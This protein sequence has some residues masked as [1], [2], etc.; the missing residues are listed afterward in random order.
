MSEIVLENISKTFETKDGTVEALKNVSL[1]I[2]KGEIYGVIGMSGAGKSTLVRCINF[3]EKPDEGKVLI[4][5]K[6][7]DDFSKKELQKQR[8]SIGMIFQHFN[9]L[10]QKTVLENVCF[11]LY[12]QKVPKKEARKKAL[13]LLELVGLV[14]RKNAYPAQLSGGQKQRVAIARALASDPK[15]LLCDEA[16]SAL[17]PQTTSSILDLLKD[18]NDKFGITIVIITHQMSVV[19][20]ICDRVAIMEEGTLAET[21]VVSEV[22]SHPKTKVAKRLIRQDID[23]ETEESILATEQIKN[24]E[25]I[26]ITFSDNSA[27]EPVIANLVLT[28]K[29]PVNILRASTKN[30]GG[31]AKGDMILEFAKDST[32]KEEMKKY[33]KEHDIEIEEN[34]DSS[35]I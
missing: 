31:I 22:F 25:I 13:E 7:L 29:E 18:I 8:E 12:I 23:T 2:D 35:E 30:V 16:T 5:G 21:G 17:D 1:T 26:R 3:L 24:G 20:K 9:L 4:E 33:L 27:F 11:P 14:E 15:I 6:S 10:M 32:N 28:F 34:V 19:R